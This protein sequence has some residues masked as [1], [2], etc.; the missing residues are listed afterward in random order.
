MTTKLSEQIKALMDNPDDLSLLPTLHAKALEVEAQE[1]EYQVRIDKLQ[2]T[3]RNLLQSIP[4]PGEPPK[5]VEPETPDFSLQ[6]SVE[7]MKN[8]L[9]LKGE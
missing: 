9:N 8:I 2:M 4:T 7:A 1:G 6:S 3:N 5:P